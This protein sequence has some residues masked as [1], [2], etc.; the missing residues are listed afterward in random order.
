MTRYDRGRA[1]E[2]ATMKDLKTNG[3]ETFRSAGS[4]GIADV[5][6]FKPGQ[7]LFVQAKTKQG[8]ISPADRVDLI[9]LANMVP[10]GVPIVVTRPKT[11]YRMLTGPGPKDWV[12]W[13]TDQV[14]ADHE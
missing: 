11:T 4:H 13:T 6:A 12:P 8:V 7:V 1:L 10:G 2:Y 14:G 9:W 5:L 3:Y